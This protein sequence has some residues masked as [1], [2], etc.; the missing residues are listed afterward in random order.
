ME[1]E[2]PKVRVTFSRGQMVKI[3]DGTFAE[4]EGKV[5]EVNQD[6]GKVRVLVSIFGRETPYE[7]NFLQIAPLVS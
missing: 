3:V 7:L 4:F 1:A 2:A 5:D 6:K